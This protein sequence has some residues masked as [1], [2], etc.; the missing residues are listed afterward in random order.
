MVGPTMTPFPD[1]LEFIGLAIAKLRKEKFELEKRAHKAAAMLE[2][3]PELHARVARS[4]REGLQSTS[5]WEDLVV[6]ILDAEVPVA[7]PELRW[8]WRMSPSLIITTNHDRSLAESSPSDCDSWSTRPD[9]S[10]LNLRR[11]VVWHLNGMGQKPSEVVLAP[12]LSGVL[13]GLSPSDA[14]YDALRSLHLLMRER[15]LLLVGYDERNPPPFSLL[16][17]IHERYGSLGAHFILTH[18]DDPHLTRARKLG[19]RPL[20][21]AKF[22]GVYRALAICAHEVPQP[23]GTPETQVELEPLPWPENEDRI[24]VIYKFQPGLKIDLEIS[25]LEDVLGT[26]DGVEVE[27]PRAMQ[28]INVLSTIR[29]YD[30]TVLHFSGHGENGSDG[31]IGIVLSSADGEDE[32]LDLEALATHLAKLARA[33]YKRVK[34]VFL[35]MCYAGAL[36]KDMLAFADVVIG[37]RWKLHSLAARELARLFYEAAGEPGVSLAQAFRETVDRSDLAQRNNLDLQLTARPGVAE[38]TY[39]GSS[40]LPYSK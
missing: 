12:E 20:F 32:L 19:L 29:Q 25:M 26:I 30:P 13:E 38:K 9:I 33:K 11:P 4:V 15:T 28:P 17:W 37:T 35:N 31:H 3:G 40:V 5:A 23:E 10:V 22:G 27:A 8:I 14:H 24:L 6:E 34:L 7:S 1:P 16:E 18:E 39:I 36:A 21:A 2:I